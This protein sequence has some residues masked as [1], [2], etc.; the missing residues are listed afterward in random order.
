MALNK[1]TDP[2][3]LP[4]G[5]F[6]PV[7]R[8]AYKTVGTLNAARDNAVLVLAGCGFHLRGAATFSFNSLYLNSS[9]SPQFNNEMRRALVAFSESAETSAMQ[10]EARTKAVKDKADELRQHQRLRG[11]LEALRRRVDRLLIVDGEVH[12]RRGARHRRRQRPR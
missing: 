2:K 11:V 4:K 5:A 8:L 12:F 3:K 7:A 1:I 6:L 10:P 9:A